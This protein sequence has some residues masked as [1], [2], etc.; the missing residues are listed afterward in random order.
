MLQGARTETDVSRHWHRALM[1][2]RARR[3]ASREAAGV[4]RR[5]QARRAGAGA[6]THPG[7][8]QEQCDTGKVATDEDLESVVT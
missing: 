8:A 4:P 1:G 5:L 7:K 6:H 2:Q 3:G